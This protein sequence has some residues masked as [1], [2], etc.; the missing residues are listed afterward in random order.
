MYGNLITQNK[1]LNDIYASDKRISQS[2]QITR[3]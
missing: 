1:I 3:V 2:C